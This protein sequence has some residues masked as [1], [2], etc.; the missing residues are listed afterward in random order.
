MENYE[1]MIEALPSSGTDLLFPRNSTRYTLL[2][3]V[4]VELIAP[5]VPLN[6]EITKDEYME[7]G[8][9]QCFFVVFCKNFNTKKIFV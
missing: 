1:N 4:Q 6:A 9:L 3:C 8:H 2:G 5:S 7:V